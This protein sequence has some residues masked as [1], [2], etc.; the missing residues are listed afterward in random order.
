MSSL[1][2]ACP[3]GGMQSLACSR[4][5]PAGP[6]QLKRPLVA[7][8]VHAAQGP[9]SSEQPARTRSSHP[10]H[11]DA[12]FTGL[13]PVTQPLSGDSVGVQLLQQRPQ[14]PQLSLG[15]MMMQMPYL[16]LPKQPQP[17]RQHQPQQPPQRPQR[18]Q[19]STSAGRPSPPA[20]LTAAD[21]YL[22]SQTGRY[23]APEALQL[24]G[25][26]WSQPSLDEL[27]QAV[28]R[29]PPEA[30]AAAAHRA[31]AEA[32]DVVGP[33][34][35][36]GDKEHQGYSYS[37]SRPQLFLAL[38][39]V[40]ADRQAQIHQQL[41]AG[42]HSI[43]SN[44][45]SSIGSAGNTGSSRLRHL[46]RRRTSSSSS[47]PVS[48][49]A[50]VRPASDADTSSKGGADSS[51]SNNGSRASRSTM[52]CSRQNSSEPSFQQQQTEQQQQHYHHQSPA[53]A[54]ES[55]A[56]VLQRLH[57]GLA[58]RGLALSHVLGFGQHRLVCPVCEGGRTSERSLA[59]TLQDPS[60]GDGAACAAALWICHRATCGVQGGF[61]LPCLPRRA[62]S[63]TSSSSTGG[64]EAASGG[65]EPAVQVG[66]GWRR[67]H[68]Q[69]R[70]RLCMAVPTCL[71]Q[72]NSKA[73]ACSLLTG[74][75][76]ALCGLSCSVLSCSLQP[77]LCPR[78]VAPSCSR[79]HQNCWP[80]W[81]E[82]GASAA[83]C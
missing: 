51:K 8:A 77:S 13:Q 41:P 79:C 10:A 76:C 6:G 60:K 65:Q 58:Q 34:L 55:E 63:S 21:G 23:S 64:I 18:R 48:N 5:C 69:K 31:A 35:L 70:Q 75:R 27:E 62:R 1:C 61:R 7:C 74:D 40:V 46:R 16:P 44:S 37:G 78:S 36:A 29:M 66:A 39:A 80:G 26:V 30:V 50:A 12:E 47:T 71:V 49:S 32:A 19:L 28:L 43:C 14:Q 22:V 56:D 17:Q 72:C 4:H 11:A 15:M 20:A 52:T 59:L 38:Q 3:H 53:V 2:R 57:E 33:G 68:M 73:P 24:Q 54:P 25:L 81:W 67:A 42:E 82:S 9:S 83:Q 45:N